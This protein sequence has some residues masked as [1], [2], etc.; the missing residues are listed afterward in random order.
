MILHRAHKNREAQH[1]SLRLQKQPL[2]LPS[3]EQF[4]Q[5]SSRPL[6]STQGIISIVCADCDP[7]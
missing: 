1:T 5:I 3:S 6:A 4:L 7:N 2:K